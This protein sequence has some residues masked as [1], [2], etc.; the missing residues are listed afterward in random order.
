MKKLSLILVTLA[1]TMLASVIVTGIACMI[2]IR[3]A[4]EVDP[5]LVLKGE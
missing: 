5:A 1:I 4:T 2:P 3:S